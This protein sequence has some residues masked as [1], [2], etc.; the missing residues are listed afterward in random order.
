M[1]QTDSVLNVLNVLNVLKKLQQIQLGTIITKNKY[2]WHFFSERA[3]E[4]SLFRVLPSDRNVVG[5][6]ESDP[7]RMVQRSIQRGVSKHWKVKNSFVVITCNTL[8]H[9]ISFPASL[10]ILKFDLF[11]W[12]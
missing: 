9:L 12:L 4:S 3:S 11:N 8:E 7:L 1:G 10:G 5:I 2:N 6:L